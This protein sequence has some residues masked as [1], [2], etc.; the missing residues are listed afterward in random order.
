MRE[1]PE[2]RNAIDDAARFCPHCGSAAA[3][4]A[5]APE[6][7]WI[8]RVVNGKFRIEELVGQGGMGRVYRARH[9]TL[10]RPVVLKMLHRTFSSDPQISQR[11]QREARAA[12]RLNHP[13]SIAVLDFGEAEDGT[14]FMAM[15]Y[16][17]GKDLARLVAE[18]FPLGEARVVRIGAQILSALSEAH[19]QGVVHRDLKP[20]N[21]MV[22]PRRA[23]PDS[24]KVLDF[25]IAKITAPGA[26]EPKLTQAGLVCGTPEYMSPE[27]ARGADIDLRSDLYSMGVI[28]YQMATGELPFASDTPVGF[29]T[30]HLSEVPVPA[31]QRNPQVEVS[32]ALDQVIAKA[33]EKD[34]AKRFQSADEM[35]AALLE[36]APAAPPVRAAA[37]AEPRR[38]RKLF[39]AFGAAMAIAVAGGG[40]VVLLARKGAEERARQPSAVAPAREVGSTASAAATPAPTSTATPT[41]T[42]TPAAT[43]PPT[44]TATPAPAPDPASAQASAAP[45]ERPSAPARDPAR[46]QRLFKQAEA[47]RAAQDVDGAIQLYLA[48]EAADPELAEVQKKLALCYQLKG[49]TKRAAERY[50]RYLATDPGDADRVRAILT[51]LR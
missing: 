11:F 46:A 34:P 18:E 24:V 6:D 19:A 33:L 39:W 15:E 50:R 31:R 8:G 47:R 30:K 42:A 23:E 32:A 5:S 21:V 45:A 12:S 44:P 37:A 14:L 3:A 29:L 27:Q 16:L 36:C 20:E 7:P 43:E 51:T 38:S 9:L 22:E 13:N 25:G 40:T 4:A 1:C 48:T 10:D 49:D 17:A 28:L 26:N 41:P 2:C 35:R